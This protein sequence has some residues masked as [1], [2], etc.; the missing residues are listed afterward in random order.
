MNVKISTKKPED[1]SDVAGY[2]KN[3]P[4]LLEI[5]EKQATVD[6]KHKE[7]LQDH[8]KFFL[9]LIH[10]H[11]HQ[12]RDITDLPEYIQNLNILSTSHAEK[13]IESKLAPILAQLSKNHTYTE[14][15][16]KKLHL[17]LGVLKEDSKVILPEEQLKISDNPV[18][19]EKEFDPEKFEAQ[20]LVKLAEQVKGTT[21]VIQVH[22]SGGGL[23]ALPLNRIPGVNISNPQNGDTLVY[24]STT[25]TW[26]NSPSAQGASFVIQLSNLTLNDSNTNTTYNNIGDNAIT[27]FTIDPSCTAGDTWELQVGQDTNGIK[28]IAGGS[29]VIRMG[30][31]ATAAGGYI[32]SIQK[33]A[34]VKVIVVNATEIFVS[35]SQR[36][37]SIN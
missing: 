17:G 24:N 31:S 25:K 23:A 37:W 6:N 7:A 33:G 21:K 11:T 5:I 8:S 26:V 18:K 9:K 16:F 4:K 15:R 22:N 36:T 20:I 1:K 27:Q 35:Y 14:D 30:A 19:K 34:V 2:L 29:R 28:L 13:L 10:N 32:Q 12:V 3:N